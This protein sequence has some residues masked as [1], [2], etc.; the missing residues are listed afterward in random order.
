MGSHLFYLLYLLYLEDEKGTM[1]N[2]HS[3]SFHDD[4]VIVEVKNLSK[5][6]KCNGQT[7]ETLHDLNLSIRRSAI[8]G[9]I[10]KSGAGKTTF[11][12]CLNLLERPTSGEVWISGRELTSLS[13]SELN[14]FR[15][16]IGVIFQSFQLLNNITVFK[17][18]ALPLEIAGE[19]TK[20]IAIR[21]RE[22]AA[23]VG[24]EG[25]LNA[26]PSQLSGGQKQR[27]AIARALVAKPTLLL[28]DE[29]T[30]ALDPET[31]LDILNLIR[32]IHA[33]LKLTIVMVTHD[34]SVVSEICDS[35]FVMD[36]GKIIEQ[37]S[38]KHVFLKPERTVTRSLLG[39][40]PKY[41]VEELCLT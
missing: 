38:V 40:S 5:Q 39:P 22:I 20:K 21:V 6:F 24:I 12:R 4:D 29:F 10:G 25:K 14:R 37:G 26:Y 33:Q 8:V 9:F 16:K 11:L 30:S 31:T 15:Q 2:T 18:I 19:S 23:L 7:V 17:N 27:V 36:S 13:K 1:L 32:R 34:M 41:F 35:V 3:E 28:C